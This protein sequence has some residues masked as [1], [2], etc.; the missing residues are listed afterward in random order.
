MNFWSTILRNAL[1]QRIL[2]DMKIAYAATKTSYQLDSHDTMIGEHLEP[3][4]LR[5]RDLPDEQK[6]RE[7]LARLGPEALSLAELTAAILGVGTTKEDVLTMA[8]R[9]IKEYGEKSIAT[10]KSA[11]KMAEAL[12]IPQSKACQLIAAFELGRRF[13][14]SEGGKAVYVRNAQ[15]AFEY[16]HTIGYSS[17]EQLRG[18]YLNSRYEVVYDELISVGSLTANIV[19]PR[20]VFR[21]A[22]EHSAVAVIIA[23]NHPSG[24]PE[25]T[26][27]DIA[28]TEQLVT[29]GKLLGIELLD[30]LVIAADQY[31]R[32]KKGL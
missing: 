21:P 1:V 24:N 27:E 30:H 5:V 13:Y 31:V 3:Y 4:V 8:A 28:V 29:A 26:T 14:A 22:I 2:R 12:D 18:L 16:V 32:I 11:I 19:H 9:I 6:P 7:K 10:E 20:E 25:P 23:H 17:K 15:Q